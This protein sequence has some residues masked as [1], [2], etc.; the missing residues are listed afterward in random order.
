MDNHRRHA[1]DQQRRGSGEHERRLTFGG[2]DAD[3][4]LPG[5]GALE[6]TANT[7][8][9]RNIVLNNIAGFANAIHV[10]GGKTYTIDGV[11]SGAGG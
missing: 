6:V 5:S 3:T 4:G 1:A 7:T 11:I 9:A 10:D 8:S 2:V